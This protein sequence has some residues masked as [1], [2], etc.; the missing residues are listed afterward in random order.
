MESRFHL[1]GRSGRGRAQRGR[2]AATRATVGQ[3]VEYPHSQAT[4]R[5][6]DV[7]RHERAEG[8]VV[9]KHAFLAKVV[10]VDRMVVSNSASGNPPGQPGG[11]STEPGEL[12]KGHRKLR[13]VDDE[14]GSVPTAQVAGTP[15][16]RRNH[17]LTVIACVAGR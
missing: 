3:V 2:G 11:V 13:H 9:G 14:G 16:A 7:P 12:P 8:L 6:L 4:A 1:G 5:C 10:R 15:V 17:S